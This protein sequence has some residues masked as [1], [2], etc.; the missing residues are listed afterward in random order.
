MSSWTPGPWWGEAPAPPHPPHSMSCRRVASLLIGLL[1][2]W[3]S[4]NNWET[5]ALLWERCQDH[6]NKSVSYNNHH[7]AFRI[8]VNLMK[9]GL[10]INLYSLT[11]YSHYWISRSEGEFQI[12]ASGT[13][14]LATFRS[15]RTWGRRSRSYLWISQNLILGVK[16]HLS[17]PQI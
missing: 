16:W 5:T 3:D 14:L 9:Q 13:C 15:L 4:Q 7:P 17:P 6:I 2:T 8:R 11:F 1:W 10:W 12:L